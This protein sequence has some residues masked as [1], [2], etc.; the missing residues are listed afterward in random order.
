M[1]KTI[2]IIQIQD[3]RRKILH[4]TR[5]RLCKMI[6]T[7]TH[8]LHNTQDPIPHSGII[9]SNSSIRDALLVPKYDGHAYFII[10]MHLQTCK[11]AHTIN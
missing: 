9:Y 2:Y 3:K 7:L 1:F 11:S 4:V 10:C 5:I 6:H 8:S